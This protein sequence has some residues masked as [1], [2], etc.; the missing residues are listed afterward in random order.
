MNIRMSRYTAIMAF[1]IS[2]LA[3]FAALKGLLNQSL[4]EEVRLAGAMTKFLVTGSLAQDFISVPL[5]LILALLSL[6]FLKRPGLKIFIAILGLTGFFFYAYGLYVIQ[7]QYTSIYLVYLAIFGLS[8]YTL[9]FGLTG[10]E[11]NAIAHYRLSW[12]IRISISLFLFLTLLVLVPVWLLRM[13]PDIG[14]HIPGDTYGVFILDLCVVFPAFGIIITQ[15]LRNKPYGNI[16]AGV[17]L[18]KALTI[19]LSVAFG[20]WFQAFYGSRQPDYGMIV[21]FSVLTIVSL[22]LLV[23]YLIKLKTNPKYDSIKRG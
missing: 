10:F 13:M 3:L 7:G 16:L 12:A 1:I 20:E 17:A 4:Y 23:F 9:L 6:V 5:G 18:L 19:T 14:R 15:L 2:F 8:I 21:I 11:L 22:V